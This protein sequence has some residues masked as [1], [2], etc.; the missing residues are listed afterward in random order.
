MPLRK[1][2]DKDINSQESDD[3]KADKSCCSHGSHS[4]S[5][6]DHNFDIAATI[7]IKNL[8]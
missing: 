2:I 8:Q 4:S 5:D 7:G 3:D 6:P 1:V